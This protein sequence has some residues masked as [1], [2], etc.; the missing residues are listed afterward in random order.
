[1]CALFVITLL[2]ALV[3]PTVAF[4]E[5]QTITAKHT[6]ILGDYDSKNDARQRC[7][8]E[9]KRKLLEQVTFPPKTST[10]FCSGRCLSEATL[11]NC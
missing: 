10:K 6:Y 7:L 5:N 2:D 1:M 4:A 9:T 3:L 11:D 8:L